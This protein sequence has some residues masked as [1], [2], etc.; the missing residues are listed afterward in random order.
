MATL[1]P[2]CTY[3]PIRVNFTNRRRPRTL[4]CILHVTAAPNATSQFGWF[5]N[6]AAQA[7]STLHVDIYGKSEQYVDADL[8]AWC[9]REGNLEYLSIETQGGAGGGWTVP[10]AAEVLRI[11]GWLANHYG[12]PL[13]DMLDSRPGRRGVGLHRYGC[14][15]YRVSGGATWGPRG[16]VCPGPDRVA[17]FK[18]G[19]LSGSTGGAPAPGPAPAWRGAMGWPVLT[20]G[21]TGADV[22]GLQMFLRDQGYTLD[23]DQRFGP[24]TRAALSDWQWKNG[25]TR[26]GVCGPATQDKMEELSMPNLEEI[27]AATAAA[28]WNTPV[29][30]TVD[31]KIE[32]VPALQELADAKTH[33]M[34]AVVNTNPIQRSAGP[35]SLRQEVADA[36]TM[37]LEQRATLAFQASLLQQMIEHLNAGTPGAVDIDYDRIEADMREVIRSEVVRVD[38]Q[39]GPARDEAAVIEAVAEVPAIESAP[40][41]E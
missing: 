27:A 34:A 16:K 21:M 26:D 32:K 20:E 22:G 40:R 14:D 28:V 13:V 12:F 3:R 35:V 23:V 41:P 33:A 36:K 18:G 17:Q 6:P 5:N 25:L 39:V 19:M 38:V 15:P 30:R 37:L 10:Q 9:Q 4:G 29:R 24:A 31:G 8:I 2:G 11:L 1:V 7:S